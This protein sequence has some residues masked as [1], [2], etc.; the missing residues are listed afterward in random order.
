MLTPIINQ[1]THQFG[2]EDDPHLWH[3]AVATFLDDV[4]YQLQKSPPPRA[5]YLVVGG[6]SSWLRPHQTRYTGRG[7]FAWP[8]GYG[9]AGY[10]RTGLPQFD[11][12]SA[13]LRSQPNCWELSDPPKLN[14]RRQVIA[15]LAI[16]TRTCRH[17]KAAVH[18]L[19]LRS[20]QKLDR[21][22]AQLYFFRRSADDWE[23]AAYHFSK[24]GWS[25]KLL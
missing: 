19:L 18:G 3:L 5:V 20:Q 22:R 15:R 12:F 23:L 9:G 6:C 2:S 8:S 1:L 21:S 4:A 10:S 24:G 16:P 13:F 7:G 25:G 11:W 17:R 14:K